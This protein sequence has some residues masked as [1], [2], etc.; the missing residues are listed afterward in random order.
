MMSAWKRFLLLWLFM[1][2]TFVAIK[3]LFNL[4]AHGWI[5]L[6]RVALL[7]VLV[8]PA[9]QTL[10]LWFGYRLDRLRSAGGASPPR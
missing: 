8:V 5:D 10:L 9:A 3:V 2:L 7:E 4:W 6:R 1:F